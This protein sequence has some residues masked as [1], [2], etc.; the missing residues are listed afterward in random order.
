MVKHE[1]RNNS[2]FCLSG[3]KVNNSRITGEVLGMLD[4]YLNLHFFEFEKDEL[5]W[6][7]LIWLILYRVVDGKST[8][9][10][11]KYVAGS[12]HF[13]HLWL[14]NGH[15]LGDIFLQKTKQKLHP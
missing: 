2:A 5:Y 8:R 10:V 9:E 11:V 1:E 7:D 14:T 15:N 12:L 13:S 3:K 4:T 6:R